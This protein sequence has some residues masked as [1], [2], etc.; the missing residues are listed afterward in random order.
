MARKVTLTTKLKRGDIVHMH[1]DVLGIV[2]RH[3]VFLKTSGFYAF[4]KSPGNRKFIR[5]NGVDW[6]TRRHIKDLVAGKAEVITRR[7]LRAM[8]AQKP[9]SGL[10]TLIDMTK[11]RK[12]PQ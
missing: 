11:R 12:R 3:E 8:Y 6:Y 5:E 7:E 4:N 9:R 1:G 10:K 2:V